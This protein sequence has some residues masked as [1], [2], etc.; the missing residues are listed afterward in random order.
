MQLTL[1]GDVGKDSWEQ[2][3][4]QQILWGGN[5]NKPERGEKF[6]ELWLYL[7]VTIA[8]YER[9]F[10][11]LKR[12]QMWIRSTVTQNRLIHIEP[13]MKIFVENTPDLKTKFGAF[14]WRW[15]IDLGF[16]CSASTLLIVVD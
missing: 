13:L 3:Q 1:W 16:Y 8:S 7:H 2:P 10:F 11:T 12:P 5:T 14:S 4:M 6:V 9:L 15:D